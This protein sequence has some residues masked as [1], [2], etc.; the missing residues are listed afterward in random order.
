MS[1]TRA[2]KEAMREDVAG[3]F[4]KATAA[5]LTEYRGLTVAEMTELRSE[6]RKSDSELKILNNRV[7]RKAAESGVSV[8]DP[9]KDDLKGPLGIVFVYGDIAAS[10][11]AIVDFS[12]A[13]EKFKVTT[14]VMEGSV[15][16]LEELKALSNLPSREVLLSQIVGSLV[17]PHRGLLGVLN[18]VSRNLVQV[19]NAI[20][21][22][23]SE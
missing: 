6:L 10:A 11:K 20:K 23:K 9:I 18:G 22:Q 15:L 4:E 14:G 19:I 8:I 1:R 7:V 5:I 3:R 16:T 12:K 21:D 2:E 13:N 17:S